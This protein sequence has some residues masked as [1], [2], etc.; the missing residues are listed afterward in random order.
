[1]ALAIQHKRSST[2][3]SQPGASDIAVGEIAIN[4]ADLKMFTKTAGNSIIEVGGES[5]VG[6]IDFTKANGTI[7][8]LSVTG[9]KLDF[10]KADGTD[11]TYNIFQQIMLFTL[12]QG[13]YVTGAHFNTHTHSHSITWDADGGTENSDVPNQLV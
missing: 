12:F 8:E 11:V 7:G 2:A 6:A 3:G 4:L 5:A 1:M 9:F 10:K 13:T